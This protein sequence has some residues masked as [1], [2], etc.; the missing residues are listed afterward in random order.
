MENQNNNQ[1]EQDMGPKSFFTHANGMKTAF[2]LVTPGEDNDTILVYFHGNQL[3]C[4]D[5]KAR[6]ALA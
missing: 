4:R 1:N 3:N 5:R 2:D 6:F